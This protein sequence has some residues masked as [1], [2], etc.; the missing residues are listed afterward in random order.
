MSGVNFSS[1]SAFLHLVSAQTVIFLYSYC[2]MSP[3][4]A[5]YFIQKFSVSPKTGFTKSQMFLFNIPMKKTT[6]LP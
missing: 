1:H 2:D 5:S 3:H 6:S 4:T